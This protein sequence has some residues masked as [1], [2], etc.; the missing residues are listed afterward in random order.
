V[1]EALLLVKHDLDKSHIHVVKRLKVD[2][3]QVELDVT[4]I[5]Q[6][7]VNLFMN[8]IHAMGSGGTLTVKTEVKDLA[9]LGDGSVLTK[10]D[11][12]N[13]K[14]NVVIVEVEDTGPGIPE[15]KLSKIF[16]PFFTTKQIGRGTGLGL[17][18]TQK[19]IDLHEGVITIRNRAEGGAR[20]TLMFKPKGGYNR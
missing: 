19:I 1:E 17:S 3:P 16:D 10:P 18:V 20:A 5:E 4:K 12:L 2:L 13:S 8:A 6:V 14:K 7:L 11:R 9:E 15:E